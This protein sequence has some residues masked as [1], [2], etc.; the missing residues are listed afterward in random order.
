MKINRYDIT[1]YA[2]VDTF[3][4]MTPQAY[5]TYDPF[6]DNSYGVSVDTDKAYAV[7]NGV[8]NVVRMDKTSVLGDLLVG[9][10]GSGDSNFNGPTYS[11]IVGSAEPVVPIPKS[12]G[13]IIW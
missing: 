3:D 10:V 7:N 11:A 8:S 6:Y 4:L 1:T 12:F 2:L 5:D 13:N 9:S